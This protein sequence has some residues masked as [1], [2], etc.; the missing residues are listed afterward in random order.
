M[1]LQSKGHWF[2]PQH[3]QLVDLDEN[4]LPHTNYKTS[5]RWPSGCWSKMSERN[6][7]A[8]HTQKKQ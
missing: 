5:F 7:F 1:A 4:S 2:D 3:R 6:T 8:K